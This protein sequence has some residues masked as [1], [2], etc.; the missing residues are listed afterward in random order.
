MIMH[1]LYLNV[2][3]SINKFTMLFL[4]WLVEYVNMFLLKK[5]PNCSRPITNANKVAT[6]PI[7]FISIEQ[8]FIV[9]HI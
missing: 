2:Y 8:I 9:Y 6:Q 1:K 3:I 4:N 5:A 7:L